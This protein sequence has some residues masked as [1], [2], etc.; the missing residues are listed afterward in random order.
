MFSRSR[1][2]QFGLLA[3]LTAVWVAL[4]GAVTPAN[5]L[6]GLLVGSLVIWLMPLPR[7]P[8]SGRVHPL[9]VLALLALTVYYA[10]EA[11]VQVAW[12]AI[13]PAPPPDAGVLRV[14]TAI[15]SDLVLVLFADVINLTPGTMV[16]EVNTLHRSLYVHVLDLSSASAAAKFYDSTHRLE[17]MFIRAFERESEWREPQLVSGRES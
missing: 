14:D 3:W 4:W 11:S 16:L 6:G 12:L 15:K 10:V 17:R 2:L 5:V 7:V 13:R 1:V 9:S 8:V